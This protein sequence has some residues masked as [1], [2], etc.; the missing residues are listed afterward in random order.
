MADIVSAFAG[1]FTA[2]ALVI[3]A[4][5]GLIAV[6]RAERKI[7][8]VHTI[9]NQQQTDLRNYIRALQRALIHEGIDIPVDQSHDESAT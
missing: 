8:T 6:R 5:A 4:V 2:V 9:V 7:D 3:S 1:V